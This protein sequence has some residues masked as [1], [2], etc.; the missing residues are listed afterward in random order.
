MVFQPIGSWDFNANL[1]SPDMT[2]VFYIDLD[3]MDGS[4]AP[5]PPPAPRN[6]TVTTI[7]AHQPEYAIFVDK[8]AGVVNAQNTW[9]Y[10]W[11]GSNWGFGQRL[12]EIGG[13]AYTSDGYVELQLL[14]GTIGMSQVTSSASVMLFSV[15]PSTG[16][17]E[18]LVPSDVTGTR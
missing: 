18:D 9:V 2:Y 17:L 3:H 16:E 7:P 15:N 6:Y 8:I 1:T 11:N 5:I 10:A 13:F 14:N 12:S 4:G